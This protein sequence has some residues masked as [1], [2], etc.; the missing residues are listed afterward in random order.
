MI[1]FV[2]D[3]ST[4]DALLAELGAAGRCD[5]VRGGR[6]KERAI[7]RF[8][9]ALRFP[10]W[11]GHNLD[12]LYELLDDHAHA[13]TSGGRHWTLVWSPSRR[14]IAEHPRDYA[15]MVGVL[16][17]VAAAAPDVP[18]DRGAGSRTV[19]VRGPDPTSPP[20]RPTEPA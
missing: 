14:L 13:A 12:A 4:L 2:D 17:D 19:L 7:A 8:A 15:R 20:P 6:T 1:L 5:V 18:P 9:E 16:A 11:F 10:G 3:D